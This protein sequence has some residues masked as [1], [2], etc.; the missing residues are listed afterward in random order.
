MRKLRFYILAIIAICSVA[1]AEE[2]TKSNLPEFRT[3][4]YEYIDGDIYNITI[5]Y[6]QITN[7]ADSRAF[8]I[9]DSMNYH[10]TFGE[11]ALEKQDLQRSSEIFKD[12]AVASMQEYNFLGYECEMHIYQVASLLRKSSVV[13][14]D[15]VIET[16]LGGVYP[17]INHSYECYDLASGNA[18][19]FSYLSEGEW[20]DALIET[21]YNKLEAQYGDMLHITEAQYLHLPVAT[22]LSDSGIVFQYQTYEIGD[23]VLGNITVELTDAELSATGA[24]ILW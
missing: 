11:F 15:T 1:C 7:T 21:I 16:N 14:Y 3:F 24:P 2:T 20:Y 5:S 4:E 22:Y 13:C 9:I 23:P 17:I 8:A 19:D 6:E 12:A 18:Y 10:T